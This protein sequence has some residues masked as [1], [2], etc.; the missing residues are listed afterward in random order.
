MLILSYLNLQIKCTLFFYYM[1]NFLQI[2]GIFALEVMLFISFAFLLFVQQIL[3]KNVYVVDNCSFPWMHFVTCGRMASE[4]RIRVQTLP[5]SSTITPQGTVDLAAFFPF[6]Y[7]ILL[8]ELVRIALS[9]VLVVMH[10]VALLLLKKENI[11][12]SDWLVTLPSLYSQSICGC[13]T[14]WSGC[15]IETHLP[16]F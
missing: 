9:Q 15:E 12:W 3:K 7:Y 1:W 14:I 4:G 8:P 16:I 11:Y 6:L 5:A 2:N 13:C 10:K